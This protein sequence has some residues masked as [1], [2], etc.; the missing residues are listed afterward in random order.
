[1]KTFAE[2]EVALAE[3]LAT[4]ESREPQ[5]QFAAAVENAL[6]TDTHLLA[7]AGCGT[8]KSFGYLIPAILSGKR[9]IISTAT[10]A[11]QDQLATGDLPFLQEH[12]GVDFTWAVLKGRANYLCRAALADDTGNGSNAVP[13][14]I[15]SSVLRRTEDADFNGERDDLGFDVENT[16][17][18]NLTVSSDDCPGK[19][20]CPFGETCYAEGAKTAAK[21]A[22]IVVVN[23][24]LSMTDIAIELASE[25]AVKMLDNYD[26]IIFD[27]AHELEE[28]ASGVFGSR[29]TKA[30]LIS[31]ATQARNFATKVGGTVRND[32]VVTAAEALWAV[33]EEGRLRP[34]TVVEHEDAWVALANSLTELAEDVSNLGVRV[35]D[36]KTKSKLQRLERRAMT[37]SRKV[38]DLITVDWNAVV[39]WVEEETT[40][41]GAKVLVLRSAPIDLSEILNRALFSQVTSVLVSATLSVDGSFDYIAGRLGVEE[42]DELD[43]GTPFDFPTQA[44]LYVPGKDFNDP[45]RDKEGWQSM[46]IAHM[47]EM[48][49]MS[50]GGA[51]LLFTSN[52]AMRRAH[53]ALADTLEG[54]GLTVLKQGDAPN[55]ALAAEFKADTHSVLFA[56]RSFFTGVDFQGETLRLVVVDKLPFPVPTEPMTEARCEAIKAAGGNDFSEYTIPVM[57]LVLK[58]ALGRLIRHKT[59][60]GVMAILDPRLRSK[61][62]G[63]VIMRSLP[64]ATDT[65]V[66]AE[67]EHYEPLVAA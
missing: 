67:A 5:Q 23:H 49:R 56:T 58:Q 4:Y 6:A 21:D 63:K 13:V 27:E 29:I 43:V 16:D 26:Y 1:M 46:A 45:A 65:E 61:G 17:W 66:L 19:K 14:T 53:M 57:T 52:A 7:E 31:L 35:G 41:R 8:G 30:A 2:A 10:K 51:L 11:L 22:Q 28:Y 32:A 24:A 48:V 44:K 15:R 64:D 3:S 33:L 60:K 9:V 50:G 54:Q 12:L 55:K 59:D 20:S 25:G 36:E 40:R 47:G 62:Y 38:I 34:N 42:Y 37:T 39:R 18:M